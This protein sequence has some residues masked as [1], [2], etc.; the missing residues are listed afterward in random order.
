MGGGAGGNVLAESGARVRLASCTWSC[1]ICSR[2]WPAA[3]SLVAMVSVPL[4]AFGPA[5]GPASVPETVPA[6]V[7]LPPGPAGGNSAD[8]IS[9]CLTAGIT[10]SRRA[11]GGAGGAGGGADGGLAVRRTSLGRDLGFAVPSPG[12]VAGLTR[13]WFNVRVC[14]TIGMTGPVAADLLSAA[15]SSPADSIPAGSNNAPK[16]SILGVITIRAVVTPRPNAKPAKAI[17]NDFVIN[18]ARRRT[19]R[20]RAGRTDLR[21]PCF[22][23]S[24]ASGRLLHGSNSRSVV[25]PV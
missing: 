19:R 18:R 22:G 14:L 6:P 2:C 20:C 24:R 11:M 25:T 16:G 21:I 10:K 15:A 5:F 12:P 23:V 8:W 7:D 1:S 9:P 17:R 4:P 13:S 3:A